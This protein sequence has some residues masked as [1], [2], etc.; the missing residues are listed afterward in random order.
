MHITFSLMYRKW[1]HNYIN[2]FEVQ[3]CFRLHMHPTL[4]S[5]SSS[6]WRVI[7]RG[8]S[9]ALRL[10]TLVW[11][12]F[13]FFSLR[14]LSKLRYVVFWFDEVFHLRRTPWLSH[15]FRSWLRVCR[16]WWDCAMLQS[17]N[18]DDF[19]SST[20]RY[21]YINRPFPCN[22]FPTSFPLRIKLSCCVVRQPN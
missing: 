13:W 12:C 5:L 11:V 1:L 19:C 7:I 8:L 22:N 10:S 14:I 15:W 20:I 18:V 21:S 4:L 16:Q 3:V 17:I 9:I 6:V 2:K